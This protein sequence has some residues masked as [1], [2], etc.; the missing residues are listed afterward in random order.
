ML[1][2]GTTSRFFAGS[3]DS[4]RQSSSSSPEGLRTD[5]SVVPAAVIPAAVMLLTGLVTEVESLTMREGV[6]ASEL[7]ISV[8]GAVAATDVDVVAGVPEGNSAIG[9]ASPTNITAA[10]V[11]TAS[12]ELNSLA[13]SI[14]LGFWEWGELNAW[15]TE[16]D[17][18][19]C[20]ISVVLL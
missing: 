3:G 13:L 12:S 8:A 18:G 16:L 2:L 4:W 11:F 5:V 17:L 20:S 19:N 1:L 6:V 10:A 7:V 14:T 9:V 15:L